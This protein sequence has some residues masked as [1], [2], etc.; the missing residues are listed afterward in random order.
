MKLVPSRRQLQMMYSQPTRLIGSVS[1]IQPQQ[2]EDSL[3]WCGIFI[4]SFQLLDSPDRHICRFPLHV[5]VILFRD[6]FDEIKILGLPPSEI[7]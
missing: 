3:N 2:Q 5:F 7:F 1:T 6:A 4:E